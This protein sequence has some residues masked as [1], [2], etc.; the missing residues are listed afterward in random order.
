MNNA[1]RKDI[2]RQIARSP[3]RFAA[4]FLVV[5][6]GVA[7]YS[8]VRSTSPDMR[9][10]VDRYFDDYNASDIQLF[11]T[12]G[13]DSEDISTLKGID[14]VRSVLPGYSADGFLMK[15]K[16]RLLVSFQSLNLDRLNSDDSIL[17]RPELT[18]GEY[19]KNENECL[20]DLRMKSEYG[21]QLGDTL[22]IQTRDDPDIRASLSAFEYKITG[23]MRSVQYISIQRGSSAKGGGHL[24]AYVFL[25][26]RNFTTD[27]Y[28]QVFL[29]AEDTG[30]SRF[31]SAYDDAMGL[32]GDRIR[33]VGT[34]RNPE[35]LAKLKSEAQEKLADGKKELKDA[36]SKLTD[37]EREL[38]NGEDKLA[39]GEK[40]LAAGRREYDTGMKDALGKLNGAKVD[41]DQAKA[42]L[43]AKR[44]EIEAGRDEIEKGKK[45]LSGT[46]TQLDEA[47]N[48]LA[49]L[50]QQIDLLILQLGQLP[51]GSEQAR[52]LSGQISSLQDVYDQKSAGLAAGESKYQEGES[53]L[54]ASEA[55]LNEGEAALKKGRRDYESGVEEYH[56]NLTGYQKAKADGKK[57]LEEA[58]KE[59]DGSKAKL[60][61]ARL[62]YEEKKP[63]A[64][65]K[66]EQARKELADGEK[67]L[68]ELKEPKWIALGLD[69]NIGFVGYRQDVDRVA[70]IGLVFPLI[71]FLVAALVSLTN[72]TRMVEDDRTT[73]GVLKALGYGRLSIAVKYLIYAGLAALGGIA[74]G[75][76]VGASLFP[77]VIYNAYG[78]LY[79]L[80]PVMTPIN[81]NSSAQAGLGA[82]FCAVVPAF[83]VCQ[84]E[85]FSTPASLMR[86][87]AP[88]QGRRILLERLPVIWK[89]LNF[90]QKVACRNIFRYKKRL[91]MTVLGIAGCTALVFTGFGL[92][93][94]IRLMVP[95]Q[96][97]ELQKYDMT[98][99]IDAGSGAD[100]SG[101]LDKLLENSG[102]VM[103]DTRLFQQMTDVKSDGDTKTASLIVPDDEERFVDFIKL[104]E[105]KTGRPI[106]LTDGGVVISEKLGRMLNLHAGDTIVLSNKDKPDVSVKVQ[107]LTENYVFHYIYMTPATYQKLY[108]EPAAVNTLLGRL[109]D[110]GRDAENR[111]S[112]A[113]LADKTV[114]SVS[115]NTSLRENFGDMVKA[116]N[117]IVLVLILSAAALAFV[118][119]FSLT[120]I[121]VD[122]R[123]REL[124]TLKVLGFYN[125]ETAMYLY[126]ENIILT[127]LGVGVGLVLGVLLLSFVLTTAEVDTVMFTR[128]THWTN[129]LF[130]SLITFGFAV[131]VNLIMSRIVTRIDMVESMKSV[132]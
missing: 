107:A 101:A 91:L 111:L 43:E 15:D 72:M 97:D 129:Y 51:E 55:R 99:N 86:P 32:F 74:L 48:A 38:L 82:L 108:G 115:F 34:K 68:N 126:R 40:E 113:L 31:S 109:K 130:S 131:A 77:R 61:D 49:A 63:D 117:I 47:A 20:A 88:R 11:S 123:K 18:E 64:L 25:P 37:A 94:A 89:R 114:S 9:L 54:Q 71:F 46:R 58:Q 83:L 73:I 120:S 75:A 39:K 96:Y 80:P 3:R 121:T 44:K 110:T 21:Y 6:L 5:A 95:I 26:E 10:T 8:G 122:E 98:V 52:Q 62:E 29:A 13:F 76:V 67:K 93:D 87:R 12:L 53:A 19:P 79:K 36:E 14:G 7:F 102:N 22:T 92:K 27:V 124:A 2:F 104:R 60:R 66:I 132:E 45:E 90:S 50:K 4:I 24:N 106:P 59:L 17:N 30:H 81:F 116:L 119:L 78:I 85:L 112:E 103:A 16:T 84:K 1:C 41:L 23:F 56:K 42:T 100:D 35:R 70:A 128:R 28:T 118:V 65:D 105:R 125:S 33:A 127:A 69:S 57:Q